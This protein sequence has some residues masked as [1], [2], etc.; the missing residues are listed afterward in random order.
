MGSI[1]FLH[2]RADETG[3]LIQFAAYQFTPEIDVAEH[4]I[5]RIGVVVIRRGGEKR[6][7]YFRPVIGGRDAQRFLARKMMEERALGD[8]RRR[9][10]VVDRR[11]GIALGADLGERRLQH[12]VA[13]GG[14][15]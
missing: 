10:E 4:A 9:T 8:A 6:A 2:H 12:F 13:R 14:L 11:R 7:C 3:E 5:E 1:G 15:G